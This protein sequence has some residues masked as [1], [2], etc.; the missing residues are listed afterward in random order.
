[1]DEKAI[2]AA[3]LTAAFIAAEH[4]D[5]VTGGR[6]ITTPETAAQWY[7][8]CLNAVEQ[9]RIREAEAARR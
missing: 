9:E 6:L 5:G 2:V 8:R 4:K 7:F 1:M 3:I